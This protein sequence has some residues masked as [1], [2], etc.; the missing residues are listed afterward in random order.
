MMLDEP[1]EDSPLHR[2]ECPERLRLID[3][4]SRSVTDL[5]RRLDS[6]KQCPLQRNDCDFTFTEASRVESQTAWEA[7]EE[8][9]A[10]HQCVPWEP[11]SGSLLEKAA[12][13]ALDMILV[14][15]DDCRCVDVNDAAAEVFGLPRGEIVGRRLDELISVVR[16]S[17]RGICALAARKFEYRARANFAP[18]FHLSVLREVDNDE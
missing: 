18:G 5:S 4:Y 17:Q 6:L 14:L 8:H 10:Q 9:I 16:G 13:A 1:K 12:M 15:D 7:L 2:A 11:N 3:E